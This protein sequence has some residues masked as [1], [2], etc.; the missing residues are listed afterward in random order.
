MLVKAILQGYPK[1][2]E[3]EIDLEPYP[4]N[5]FEAMSRHPWKCIVNGEDATAAPGGD[6]GYVDV[7]VAKTDV[8]YWVNVYTFERVIPSPYDIDI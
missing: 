6:G 5:T 2:Q 4:P 1:S 7:R 3:V 8:V